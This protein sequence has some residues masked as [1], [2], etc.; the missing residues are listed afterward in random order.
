[1]R[2]SSVSPEYEIA[3]TTS[4]AVSMPRSP[5]L[6]SPGCMKNAGVPVEAS[7]EAILRADVPRLAHAG[8]HHA[9][10][11]LE[12][13]T[14]RGEEGLAQARLERAHR[15]GLDVEDV[16]RE[17]QEALRVGQRMGL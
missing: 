15:V 14:V 11:R 7:V 9:A 13:Q 6:A 2:I 10:P 12:H 16:A 3:S 8:H 5:W 4:C 17:L 1:M